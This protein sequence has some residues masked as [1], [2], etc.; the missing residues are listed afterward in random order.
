MAQMATPALTTVGMQNEKAGRAAVD[1]LL[2]LLSGASVETRRDLETALIVR[3][4]TAPPSTHP[5]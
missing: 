5:R 3:A 1:L 4:S 2:S